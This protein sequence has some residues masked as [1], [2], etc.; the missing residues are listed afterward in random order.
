VDIDMNN[1]IS[2]P[3]DAESDGPM[4]LSMSEHLFLWG[5]RLTAHHRG[6]GCPISGAIKQVYGQYHIADVVEALDA[7]IEAFASTAHTAIE[8]H[9][10]NCPCVS[11]SERSLLRAMAA[12][13]SA[14]LSKAHREFER[15]LPALAVDWILGPARG[16][17]GSF[18]AAGMALPLRSGEQAVH[19]IAKCLPD[20]AKV[21]F[22]IDPELDAGR[23]H[24]GDLRVN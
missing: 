6:C 13:Q 1:V 3:H 10:P 14:D 24:L 18:R 9:S 20:K 12:A 23:L 19:K 4:Q 21:G 2:F 15:W 17:A 5:F 7:M 8:I 11:E 16:I 22:F